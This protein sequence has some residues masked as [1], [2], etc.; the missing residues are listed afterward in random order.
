MGK[1]SRKRSVDARRAPEPA[2]DPAGADPPRR[3]VGRTPD[4]RARREEA[5]PA[6][7]GAFPLTE[8]T[9]FV[10]LTLVVAGFVVGGDTRLVLLIAG[11][12]VVCLAASELAVREHFAGFRSHSA[13]LG[14]ALGVICM[15][16][17][18]FLGLPAVVPIAVG[19]VVGGAAFVGLRR[20]FAQ[21]S[22]GL[23]F[24]A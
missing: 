23:K 15:V 22:G 18:G 9:I 11:F 2:A 4:V 16:L 5:P 7:W 19:L 14:A 20:V 1:R 17:L 12:T 13:L 10:G 3:P 6:P 8:L 21:R 24:R